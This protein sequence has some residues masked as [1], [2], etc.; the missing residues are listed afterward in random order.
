MSL[1]CTG[2]Y[3]CVPPSRH[4]ALAAGNTLTFVS[5]CSLFQAHEGP[6]AA[7]TTDAS[8]GLLATGSADRGL[9]VWD[10]AVGRA[11]HNF[12]GHQGIVSPLLFHPDHRRL[13]LFSGG[14]EG[15]VY[16]WDLVRGTLLARFSAHFSAITDLALS[17]DGNT[18]LSASRD[19][20]RRHGRT[21]S[22]AQH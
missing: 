16:L 17:P 3:V 21:A 18:L 5:E 15:V 13:Q 1:A 8:G 19:K 11:T 9:R 20:V 12:R 4:S 2:T 14:A 6:V 10:V 22:A 7:L